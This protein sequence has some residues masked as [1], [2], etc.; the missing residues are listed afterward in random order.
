MP[1]LLFAE[2][3]VSGLAAAG[4]RAVCIAPGSRST[5]LA[6]AFDAHPQI[7]TF[8]HLDERCAGFFALGMAQAS[9]RP[10]A[11]VCT[12]GTAALEFHAAAVEAQMAGVPL[13]LLT[14]DR[15]PE[16]RHSGANQTIDQVKMYGDHVLWAV[17][18]ALPE[19]EPP[20]VAL[21]NLSTLAARAYA[22]ADGLRKGPVQ[23]NLPFRK[24]LEP[25]P[26][27][28][29]RFD[30]GQTTSIQQGIL[31]PTT[32][33]IDELAALIAQNERGWIVCG[34]WAGQAPCALVDAVT[35]LG[36]R[37][38]YPL[39]ADPLSG[40]RFGP[41]V[42]STTVLG[43]YE[44]FLQHP[45][46]FDPPQVV[47]RFGAVPTSKWLN[48]YLECAAPPYQIHVRSS[49]VWGDDS[50]RVRF[51]LQ[52][53]EIAFCRRLAE[54]VDRGIGSWSAAVLAAEQRTRRRQAQ[55]LRETWFDAAAI[56]V[57]LDAL[58]R[59]ANLFVGNSLPV[60]HLDQFGRPSRRQIHIYGN[61]GASG[62]DGVVSS[63]L[64][65]AAAEP[66][67]PM[68]LLIGDVSF[69]HD[70]NGLLAIRQRN[71]DNVTIVLFHNDGGGIFRRLPVAQ[72]QPQF[73]ELFLT[74]HGLDFA[75]AAKMYGLDY[76]QISEPK[77]GTPH[78]ATLTA[79]LTASLNGARP[80]VIEVRTDGMQDER[81]RRKMVETLRHSKEELS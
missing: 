23:I 62:I 14:A 16:L 45:P 44:S 41:H 24:P 51:F 25:P 43:S 6:L 46:D 17:D 56:P 68:L 65:V 58:T 12:S 15:P 30:S 5:P 37:T 26:P 28:Q 3:L 32:A 55:F 66:S 64:G 33:Q 70:L 7:E 19:N 29:P 40:L 2:T 67:T 63:A 20:Q 10:V 59:K 72:H 8:L 38:G 74:P 80:T 18:A 39:L 31:Q 50:H 71:L 53:D 73:K 48:E 81:L 69:Y 9:Q 27:Y 75:P 4:L 47:I 42:A 52:V 36:R 35:D 78:R 49:G 11:L 60:R 34:P 54:R 79:A 21:R 13:L 61:R 57:I 22:I 77:I 76:T 1:N